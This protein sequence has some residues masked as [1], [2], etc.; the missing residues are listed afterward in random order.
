M[1]SNQKIP[2]PFIQVSI[3]DSFW[4]PRILANRTRGLDAVYQQLEATGRLAAYDLDW[5][6]ESGQ[7]APHVFW[8]SDVAKW[9]E[10]ACLSLMSHPDETLRRRVESVVDRILSAQG[11]DGY[12]N[13]HFTVVNPEG[14]WT[15]LRD[16]HELYCAGH[17]LEAAIAHHRATDDPRFLDAV[18]RYIDLIGRTFGNGENQLPGYPGHEE[19]ELAL[20]ELYHHTGE[21]EALKLAKYFIDQ[22]G[23]QPHYFD[24]EAQQRGEN[25]AD[26]WAGSHAYTQSHQPVREQQE[27][28]GHAVRGMYLYSAMADL[29]K[30]TGDPELLTAL[31]TLWHDLTTRKLYLTGGIGSSGGNEGFTT[32]YDL[33]NRDAYAETCAAIGLIFWAHRM[34]QL[35]LDSRYSDVMERALY[36]GMLSG[37]SL[38]GDQFLL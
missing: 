18:R 11:E 33:P 24:R 10:G 38:G 20:M 36:N 1:T 8:D 28:V 32:Q 27:V 21:T 17:L 30:E 31:K 34:L 4:A 35:E 7:P 3:T 6:P 22:R 23:Q 5:T 13:P 26:Y 14:R 12:L 19:L 15:N 37:V 16:K 2:L 29:A 9:L 25:P